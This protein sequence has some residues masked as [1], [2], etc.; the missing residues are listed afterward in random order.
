MFRSLLRPLSGARDYDVD[1]PHWLAVCW[2]L[3]AVRPEQC[4]GCRL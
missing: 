1:L 3:G 4:P 2:R